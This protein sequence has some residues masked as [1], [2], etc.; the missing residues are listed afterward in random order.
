VWLH[1]GKAREGRY[2]C[3]YAT[4]GIVICEDSNFGYVGVVEEG[5]RVEEVLDIGAGGPGVL[6]GERLREDGVGG[7]TDAPVARRGFCAWN[8]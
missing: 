2:G 7:C 1:G 5:G 6:L 4:E 8:L 3:G